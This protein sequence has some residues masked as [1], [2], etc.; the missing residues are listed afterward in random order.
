MNEQLKTNFDLE[1]CKPILLLD[2]M[3][4]KIENDL[5]ELIMNSDSEK[6]MNY[7]ENNDINE[8]NV[9]KDHSDNIYSLNGKN[10]ILIKNAVNKTVEQKSKD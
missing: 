9:N 7:S 1:I 2:Q 8:F 5:N 6:E 10:N 4:D 3:N